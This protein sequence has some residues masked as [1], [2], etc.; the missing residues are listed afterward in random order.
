MKAN[1]LQVKVAK[2]IIAM[3]RRER[4]AANQRLVASSIA[5]VLGVSRSPVK[6]ALG[7]LANMGIVEHDKNRGFFLAKPADELKDVLEGFGNGTEDELYQK[8]SDMHLVGELPEDVNEAELM[9]LFDVSR[10]TLRKCLSRIL[11]E[12]WV[13]RNTGRGWHFLPVVDSAEAYEE[14]YYYRIVI[15]PAAILSPNF[16][17]D[18]EELEKLIEEQK[19]ISSDGYA[20]M[21]AQELFDANTKFHESVIAWS[22]NRFMLQSIKRLNQ[23]RRLV[24]YKQIRK[25]SSRKGQSSEHLEILLFIREMDY[26][27]AASLMR[28]H[29]EGAKKTKVYDSTLFHDEER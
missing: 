23:L 29:L 22:G 21:T 5:E 1:E 13:E 20:Y 25:R 11:Q 10:S 17:P 3:A 19:Y 6:T 4:Y 2:E 28:R 24:E 9:R 18:T 27:K 7:L 14:S 8:I 15:E 26:L 16:E 12:G